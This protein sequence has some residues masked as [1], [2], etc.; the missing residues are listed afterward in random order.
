MAGLARV[1]PVLPGAKLRER[2][3]GLDVT[4]DGAVQLLCRDSHDEPW[5]ARPIAGARV[6]GP[7]VRIFAHRD[8]LARAFAFGLDQ[9]D[10]ID[11]LGPIRLSRGGDLMIVMPQRAVGQPGVNRPATPYRPIGAA[12]QPIPKPNKPNTPPQPIPPPKATTMEPPIPTPTP[13]APAAPS[14]DTDVETR[15]T[16]IRQALDGARQ[17]L[18]SVATALKLARQQRHKTQRDLQTV[19]NTLRTL[20]RVDL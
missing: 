15:L 19:R 12:P 16:A 1:L 18:V 11:P 8:Y 4:E 10:V 7:P 5:E 13:R 6:S 20:Q 14:P 3:V 17:G 2:P 9:V